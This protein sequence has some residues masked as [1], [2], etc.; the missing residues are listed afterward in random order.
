[1]QNKVGHQ[2]DHLMGPISL[3]LQLSIAQYP[4]AWPQYLDTIMF[5]NSYLLLFYSMKDYKYTIDHVILEQSLLLLEI[6]IIPKCAVILSLPVPCVRNFI[7][8]APAPNNLNIIL[9][10]LCI[11]DVHIIA[12]LLNCPVVL[13]GPRHGEVST[14]ILNITYCLSQI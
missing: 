4:S 5:F 13:I 10:T 6:L 1:M 9:T 12:V 8:H 14:I 11:P 2:F 3:K 7:C